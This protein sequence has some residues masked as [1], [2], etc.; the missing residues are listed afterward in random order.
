MYKNI[1]KRGNVRQWKEGLKMRRATQRAAVFFSRPFEKNL[2]F[3][4]RPGSF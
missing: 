3:L 2:C 4:N 1:Y